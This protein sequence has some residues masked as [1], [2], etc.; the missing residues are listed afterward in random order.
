MFW[1]CCEKKKKKIKKKKKRVKETIYDLKPLE[2][3]L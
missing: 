2:Q 1:K 3:E